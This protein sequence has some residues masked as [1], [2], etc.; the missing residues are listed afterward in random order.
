[1]E[2]GVSCEVI[3]GGTIKVGDAARLTEKRGTIDAGNQAPGYYVPPSKRTSE[4]VFG[5]RK[6]MRESKKQLEAVDPDGVERVE[7]S[8]ATVGLSFWPKG[9]K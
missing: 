1:M 3:V 2:A 4:M 6:I 9:D 8:Y 7:T 5:A